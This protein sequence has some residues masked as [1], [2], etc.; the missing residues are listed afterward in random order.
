MRSV[1]KA[2]LMETSIGFRPLLYESFHPHYISTPFGDL[3]V[4]LHLG[5][6]KLQPQTNLKNVPKEPK[7]L[8]MIT[9]TKNAKSKKAQKDY[10]MK[11]INLY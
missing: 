2:E 7:R 11:V 1:Q 6:T 10:K 3:I 5:K 4:R 8:K 9:K